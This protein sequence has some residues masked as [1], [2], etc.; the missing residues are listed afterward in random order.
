MSWTR[1]SW[2]RMGVIG[3]AHYGHRA[4]GFTGLIVREGNTACCNCTQH[5][6]ARLHD[7]SLYCTLSRPMP[8]QLIKLCTKGC[9]RMCP[10]SKLC[11]SNYCWPS[12]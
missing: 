11:K 12:P 7:E 10:S 2:P 5:V 9:V 4:N 3:T 6:L 1:L 8:V